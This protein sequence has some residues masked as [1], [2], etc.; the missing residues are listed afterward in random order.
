MKMNIEKMPRPFDGSLSVTPNSF[1]K[2]SSSFSFAG[3]N[4]ELLMSNILSVVGLI[5]TESST[6]YSIQ[7]MNAGYF[8]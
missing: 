6:H 3:S 8:A 2:S 1:R 4:F 7:L 5:V